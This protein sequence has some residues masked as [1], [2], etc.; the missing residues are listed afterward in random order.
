[1]KFSFIVVQHKRYI[2]LL[3]RLQLFF[4]CGQVRKNKEKK[5]TIS[6]T[7][8][9]R[10]RDI[11][12]VCNII[13]PFCDKYKLN[14]TKQHEFNIFKELAFL[15]KDKYHLESN[16]NNEHCLGLAKSLMEIRKQFKNRK[17]DLIMDEE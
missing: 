16:K 2:E 15:L 8:Q 6:N 14:I 10:V 17:F 1:M 7:W 4:N 3:H 11:Q 12:D 13:I 5:N 9:L